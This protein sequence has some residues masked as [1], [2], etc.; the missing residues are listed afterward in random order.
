MEPEWSSQTGAARMEQGRS[1]D[2][3]F[4]EIGSSDGTD[5]VTI[6]SLIYNVQITITITK[7]RYRVFHTTLLFHY[8]QLFISLLLTKI[9]V[10]FL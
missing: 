4:V 5:A 8:R 1:L 3:H 6:I 9:N 7:I 10:K 2:H